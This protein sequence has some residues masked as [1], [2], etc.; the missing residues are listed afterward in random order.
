MFKRFA[1]FLALSSSAAISS[2]SFYVWA[3]G[4]AT[5]ITGAADYSQYVQN[6]YTSVGAEKLIT[7]ADSS[8]SF[9]SVSELGALHAHS[10]ISAVAV[11]SS[12]APRAWA[13][14]QYR[15]SITVGGIGQITLQFSMPTN[16]VFAADGYNAQ[17]LARLD[18][19]TPSAGLLGLAVTERMNSG[20]LTITDDTTTGQITVDAG[21]VL[22]LQ[23]YLAT[24]TRLAPTY[25]PSSSSADFSN[26]SHTFIEVMTPGGSVTSESGHNYSQSAVPEP[27]SLSLLAIGAGLLARKRAA[28]AA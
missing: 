8:A 5:D 24:D 4:Q 20:V 22:S 7:N 18:V 12:Y 9:G 15:D 17:V 13:R 21:T 1:C 3:D 19:G 27:A 23:G 25:Y 10:Q 26:T 2:A 16:G 28:K 14:A 11:G 6:V